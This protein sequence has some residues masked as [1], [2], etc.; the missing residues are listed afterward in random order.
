MKLYGYICVNQ[1]EASGRM[2]FWNGGSNYRVFRWME[3]S[4]SVTLTEDDCFTFYP[5]SEKT[6]YEKLREA[7]IQAADYVSFLEAE[8]KSNAW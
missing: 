5:D 2:V 3:I 6:D 4:G 1:C 8:R 7:R